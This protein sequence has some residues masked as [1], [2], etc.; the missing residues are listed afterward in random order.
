MKGWKIMNRKWLLLPCLVIS[1]TRE[2]RR[3]RVMWIMIEFDDRL[4]TC[5]LDLWISDLNWVSAS[6]TISFNRMFSVE[7]RNHFFS[8]LID[9]TRDAFSTS[10]ASLALASAHFYF[11]SLS[12]TLKPRSNIWT[13]VITWENIARESEHV[14]W[15][16]VM[17]NNHE[18]SQMTRRLI[19]SLS[20]KKYQKKNS[21]HIQRCRS[22]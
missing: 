9:F 7:K 3:S 8:S 18:N 12:L 1:C 10:N 16:Q 14:V 11:F 20:S 19:K 17:T 5:A 13:N 2:W 4:Y 6:F 21:I 15:R 22:M